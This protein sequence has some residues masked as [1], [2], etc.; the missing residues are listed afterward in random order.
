MISHLELFSG[1]GG[2]RM[3]LDLLGKDFGF[4]TKCVGFSEKD[5]YASQT[6]KANFDTSNEIE[7][8]DIEYFTSN[9][10]EISKLDNFELLTGGFPCQSF[11][12]M[13]KQKGLSD[14]RGNTFYSITDILKAKNDSSFILLENVQRLR[15]HDNGE[16]FKEI[17]KSLKDCGFNYIYS[18]VFNSANFNLAQTRNRIF[19][20]GSRKRL[21]TSF[22]FSQEKVFESFNK[23][24]QK[25]SLIKQENILD[26]LSKSVDE[27]YYLSDKIKP[28]I[29][30]NGSKNFISKSEINLLIARPLTASMVKMHRACQD[31][32]YSDEFI[33]SAN[34]NEYRTWEIS[35]KELEKH[36]IRKL[37]PKEALALQG[38]GEDFYKNAKI[39][40]VSDHQILKQAGNAVSVNTVYAI[41]HHL[42]VKNGLIKL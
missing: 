6:Y 17:V 25:I 22:E 34:P 5:K 10:S 24:E 31:N 20:F 36:R 29:L 18:D 39:S 21:P 3:A 32:Y 37:T 41:L 2:F 1:I 23:I 28:T 9:K 15:T 33:L 40:G 35:K 12:M 27:K 26:V 11:S 19:I 7:I 30:A 42:F 13:G 38:F 8:G 4:K 14:P 16:T